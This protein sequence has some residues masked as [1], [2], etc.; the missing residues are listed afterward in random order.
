MT[1]SP[2]VTVAAVIEHDGRYLLVQER[3]QG[4]RVLNQPAGHL[5]PKESLLEAVIR[6]VREETCRDFTPS[7]LIGVYRWVSP[8][9]LTFLRFAFAGKAGDSLPGCRRDPEIEGNL[10]LSE[11]EL[12]ARDDQ[13]RSPLVLRCIRDARQGAPQPLSLLRDLG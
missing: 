5:E 4:R 8:A 10:W 11:A 13:L 1:W 9:G 7:G 2:R 3:D 12:A 6:E